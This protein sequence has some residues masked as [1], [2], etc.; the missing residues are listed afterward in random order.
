[1]IP[2]LISTAG[3]VRVVLTGAFGWGDVV[4]AADG[5]GRDMRVKN[6]CVYY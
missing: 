5:I 3:P 4:E 1:V 2:G 6:V